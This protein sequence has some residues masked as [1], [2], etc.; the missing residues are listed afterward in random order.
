MAGDVCPRG[1]LHQDGRIPFKI[2]GSVLI[3]GMAV[4]KQIEGL[5]LIEL[6]LFCPEYRP[7]TRVISR[8]K[9]I[10]KPDSVGFDLGIEAIEARQRGQGFRMRCIDDGAAGFLG[11][12]TGDNMRQFMPHNAGK[13]IVVQPIN[14]AGIEHHGRAAESIGLKDIVFDQD[15]VYFT[16][17]EMAFAPHLAGNFSKPGKARVGRVSNLPHT[18]SAVEREPFIQITLR[19][20]VHFCFWDKV[21]HLLAGDMVITLAQVFRRGHINRLRYRFE[22]NGTAC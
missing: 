10:D 15:K 20:P 14:K 5:A 1:M 2:A 7:G 22:I 13:C 11:D 12:M 16:I 19:A 3:R 8:Q 21:E 18:K 6:S 4:K 9:S 17:G